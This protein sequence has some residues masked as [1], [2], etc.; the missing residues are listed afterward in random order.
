MIVSGLPTWRLKKLILISQLRISAL[1]L[2]EMLD[3]NLFTRINLMA[4][5]N[6]LYNLVYNASIKT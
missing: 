4:S 5:A 6:V 2:E 1:T 3:G